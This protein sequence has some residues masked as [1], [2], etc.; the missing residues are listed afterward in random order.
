M[1]IYSTIDIT[2]RDAISKIKEGLD[3]ATDDEVAEILFA[4]YKKKKLYNY[5]IVSSYEDPNRSFR[6][7][8]YHFR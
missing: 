7:E 2:R 8:D 6:K 3:K 5:N 4:L 1:G